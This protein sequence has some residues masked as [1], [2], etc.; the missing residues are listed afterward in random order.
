V[1]KEI[2]IFVY[3]NYNFQAIYFEFIQKSFKQ[4]VIYGLATVLPRMISFLLNPF[5][6][7]KLPKQ[8]CRCFHSFCLAGFLQRN[9]ILRNGLLFLDF[10]IVDNKKS[11]VSTTTISLLDVYCILGIALINRKHFQIGQILTFNM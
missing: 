8:I 4:T 6:V 10:T 7:D 5:Y 9:F 2:V 11:V 1:I 3:T